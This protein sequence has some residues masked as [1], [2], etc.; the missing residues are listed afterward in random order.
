MAGQ[1]VPHVHVHILPRV[2][3]DLERNDDIYS[4][5]DGESASMMRD[6]DTAL[7]QRPTFTPVDDESR[8]PRSLQEMEEEARWLASFFD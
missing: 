4:A 8:K 1:S 5:I 3:G 6:W 7:A 2:R